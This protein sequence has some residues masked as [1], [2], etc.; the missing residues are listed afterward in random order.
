[1]SDADQESSDADQAGSTDDQSASARDQLAS[2]RDQQGADAAHAAR[3]EASAAEVD[4]FEKSRTERQLSSVERLSRRLERVETARK[5]AQDAL[6]RDE[7]AE[8]RDAIALARDDHAAELLRESEEREAVLVR[9]LEAV[10]RR[11]A[12]ERMQA[13]RDRA[14]AAAER[15]RL[16]EERARLEAQLRSAHQDDLTGAY[17]R[18]AGWTALNAEIQRARRGDG[19]LVVAF[20]DVDRLKDVNDRHG[21][22]AGDQ[23][24]ET[25]VRTLRSGL[26]SFDIVI[27]YG[28]DE[29]VCTLGGTDIEAAER[30][31]A[32]LAEVVQQTAGAGISVGLAALA[33]GDAAD[34]I[35]RR[36][37]LAMLQVKERR[38]QGKDR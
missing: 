20:V 27:R 2:D 21:H 22:A 37:D 23:V 34:D 28:G 29:F 5:R 18:E 32:A 6:L 3:A 7:S 31:F 15:A 9:Q 25:V 14:R 10:R 11:A 36:A 30:R 4:S 8:T 13:A 12:E 1:M 35:T 38:R 24:I 19:K 17:R 16:L 26:R 33:D